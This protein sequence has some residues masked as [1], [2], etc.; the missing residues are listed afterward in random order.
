MYMHV[1]ISSTHSSQ[2]TAPEP[3]HTTTAAA[4]V[5]LTHFVTIIIYTWGGGGYNHTFAFF[6]SGWSMQV[7]P[8]VEKY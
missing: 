1:L 4:A 2:G 7:M 8:E 3:K 6:D 5:D